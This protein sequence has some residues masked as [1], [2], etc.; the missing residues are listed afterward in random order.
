VTKIF[1]RAIFCL[2]FLPSLCYAQTSADDA[3]VIDRK[4]REDVAAILDKKQEIPE[5]EVEEEEIAPAKKE[6]EFFV[7]DIRIEGNTKISTAELSSLINPYLNQKQT[8]SRMRRLAKAIQ[9]KF[10][11]RGYIATFVYLPPQKIEEEIVIIKVIEGKLGSFSV[12]GNRF[13]RKKRT[14]AY[15]KLKSGEIVEYERLRESLY[16]MNQNPDRQVRLVLRKGEI[17]ETTDVSFIVKDRFPV[18]LSY[19]HDN[20]GARTTGKNRF[21]FILRDTNLTS[22]DDVLTGGV[23]FGSD[24]ASSS[25]STFFR[26]PKPTRNLWPALVTP[27]SLLKGNQGPLGSMEFLKLFMEGSF[28]I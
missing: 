20:E 23:V 18:H 8:V 13:F 7:K 27:R 19:F 15:S 10:R 6:I 12:E 25:R 1:I 22:F 14:L 5:P 28:R 4:V 16:H 11:S 17:P 21:G 3:G 26:F 9:A 24:L 2:L